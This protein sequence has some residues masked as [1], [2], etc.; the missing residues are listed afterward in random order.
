MADSENSRILPFKTRRNILSA[1]AALCMTAA[2]KQS[3]GTSQTSP[4]D[5]A[6]LF[7]LWREWNSAHQRRCELTA[8]QRQLEIKL[9][10]ITDES[11]VAMHIPSAEMP[12][13]ASSVEEIEQAPPGA[14]TVDARNNAVERLRSLQHE[15]DITRW[16]LGY[17]Q[18]CEE[19]VIADRLGP[20]D[21]VDSQ[22]SGSVIQDCFLG[23]GFGTRRPDGYGMADHRGAVAH[24][25]R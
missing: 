23:D 11:M 6:P 5:D 13:F 20:V 14:A 4:K 3:Y 18:A 24:R 1:G 16:E 7:A 2:T 17:T 21:K 19:E 15:W 22:I 8:L 25:T 9:L 10:D 12:L